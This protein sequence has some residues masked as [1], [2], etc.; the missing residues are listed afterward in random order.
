LVIIAHD[1]AIRYNLTLAGWGI[2]LFRA[3]NLYWRAESF[4][5]IRL[6]V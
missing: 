6:Y 1:S 3:R 5:K 2:F 4:A